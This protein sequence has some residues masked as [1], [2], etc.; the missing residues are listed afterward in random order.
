MYLRKLL[1]MLLLSCVIAAPAPAEDGI[2]SSAISRCA[3]KVGTDT[4]HSDAAFGLIALDGIPWLAIERTEGSVGTQPIT[5]TVTGTGALHRRNGTF[6]P[7]RFTCVLDANGQALMFHASH[8]M[9]KLGDT[10]PPATVVAGSASYSEKMLLPRGVELRVQL[11]DITESSTGDVVAEQVVRSGWQVPI[12]FALLVPK[13]WSPGD[14]KLLLTA[15]LVLA[16]QTL[17]Q[18]TEPRAMAA[19]DLHKPVELL[20]ERVAATKR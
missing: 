4:R 20:L 5:T 11:L 10:L 16:H 8:L 14:R 2:S 6:V 12:P 18:L 1:S 13:N 19:A 15:R 9:P 3:G 7:F 17:F